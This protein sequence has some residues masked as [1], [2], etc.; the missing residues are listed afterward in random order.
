MPLPVRSLCVIKPKKGTVFAQNYVEFS[1]PLITF[2]NEILACLWA[3][4]KE[5]KRKKTYLL[6]NCPICLLQPRVASDKLT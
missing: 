6:V 5:L 4:F 3:V 1:R 2:F